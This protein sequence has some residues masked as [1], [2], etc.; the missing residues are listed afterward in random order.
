M[1]RVEFSR[2]DLAIEAKHLGDGH[3]RLCARVG[4]QEWSGLFPE[5]ALLPGRGFPFGAALSAWKNSTLPPGALERGLRRVTIEAYGT[6]LASISW[7]ALHPWG[8]PVIRVT[9]VRPNYGIDP[10]KLPLRIVQLGTSPEL[11]LP[12]TIYSLFGKRRRRASLRDAIM[13]E[14]VKD[15]AGLSS[16]SKLGPV[17]DVLHFESR[18]FI[19]PGAAS[20]A[21][22][23]AVGTAAWLA[24]ICATRQTRLVVLHCPPSRRDC[25]LPL[26]AVLIGA[27]G[28][29]VLVESLPRRLR[30]PFYRRFYSDLMHDFPLDVILEQAVSEVLNGKQGLVS[31][32]AGAGREDELRVS[33]I[34][35]KALKL[36]PSKK[37]ALSTF[38]DVA[39]PQ[40]V[41]IWNVLH[42][43]RRDWNSI[44]FEFH[45]SEGLLPL[46][47]KVK[48]IRSILNTVP[49]RPAARS[50]PLAF[51]AVRGLP[52][53]SG[54][55]LGTP[56]APPP[57]FLNI[58]FWRTD[59]SGQL[60][61]VPQR[62]TGLQIEQVI[63]LAI[64]IGP[65]NIRIEVADSEAIEE[66]RFRWTPEMKGVWV[67]IGITGIDCE[68]LGNPVRELWLPRE[69]PTERLY[70]PV[71]PKGTSG[72]SRLRVTLYHN[73]DVIQS[74]RVA[75]VTIAGDSL[76]PPDVRCK[77]LARALD[78]A[79]EK[80]KD[81]AFFSRLEYSTGSFQDVAARSAEPSRRTLSIVVN[82]CDN[83]TV[84]TV[85][86]PGL[87]SARILP[88][89]DVPQRV[90]DLR[91]RLQD[92]SDYTFKDGSKGYAFGAQGAPNGGTPAQLNDA[93]MSLALPG[94]RL[95]DKLVLEEQREE[96]DRFLSSD[97]ATIHV[98]HILRDKV[99][100]WNLLYD[101]AYDANK[102][103][104]ADGNPV[105][106]AV[107]TAALPKSDGT[108]PAAGCFENPDCLLHGYPQKRCT[109][110]AD[111]TLLPETVICPRRFWGFRHVIEVPPQQVPPGG[112]GTSMPV[113]IPVAGKARIIA[114]VNC[115][116]SLYDE[117]VKQIEALSGKFTALWIGP[118]FDRDRIIELL[119]DRDL[120]VIYFYCHAAGGVGSNLT[121][122]ELQFQGP[123]DK[124][125]GVIT[126]D[127]LS[128]RLKW[129]R[130]PLVFLNGCGTVGYTPESLTPFI[131]KLVD[132][133]GASGI[134]GTE[135]PVWEQ[136][137]SEIARRFF[138]MFLDGQPAG[139]ALLLARRQILAQSN[140]LG[141]VYT[142][143][144]PAD[145]K[146]TAR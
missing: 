15:A 102:R 10:F 142:L 114:G 26:A 133:R 104:D 143:Y 9:Q 14:K 12:Q 39:F 30:I 24:R 130:N 88:D 128:Y 38:P 123:E 23:A 72:V 55:L 83:D 64:D 41:Q 66:E 145:L 50:I 120:S 125:V 20:F 117:H 7:E 63:Q 11:S 58:G 101:R 29:A 79:P 112:A 33:A 86:G 71:V 74:Y 76:P 99:I 146:L 62:N 107:C 106:H 68:V 93:L 115:T 13:V 56:P 31:L 82:D 126:P 84:V 97:G 51:G 131:K 134:V 80:V 95:F 19:R 91:K 87:F 5:N 94:W 21:D 89:S 77:L 65:K 16:N 44:Q 73:Q 17:S 27:G 129:S 61:Q 59:P 57:R 144:A 119:K 141:L 22:P 96:L 69:G 92:T 137:A 36:A 37:M 110:S 4:T 85:K 52:M 67:E 28:P 100:P 138:E 75:A 135:V 32:F 103:K 43:L 116:L 34:G 54:R 124:V 140:P 8:A 109:D 111:K 132:D 53:P 98:A 25:M 48:D 46:A 78:L 49:G 18:E 121:D 108:L 105:A 60:K 42:D 122:P 6:I 127:E 118:E 3:V 81:V 35:V 70:F 136:L 113:G 40:Q 2:I 1:P 47:A 45:E 90:Q 139:L